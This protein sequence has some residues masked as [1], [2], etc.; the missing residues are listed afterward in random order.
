[1]VDGLGGHVRAAEV[2]VASP[3]SGL[4][5]DWSGHY[6]TVFAV[7]TV[8]LALAFIPAALVREE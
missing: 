3:L 6:H 7:L 1:M 5:A 4:V 8:V 2:V